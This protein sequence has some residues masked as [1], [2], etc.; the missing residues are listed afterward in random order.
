VSSVKS[1]LSFAHRIGYTPFNVGVVVK[2]P[3]S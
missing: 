1:L 3:F 2:L